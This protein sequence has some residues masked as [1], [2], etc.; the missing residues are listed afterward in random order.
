MDIDLK[1]E[2]KMRDELLS[3]YEKQIEIQEKF[4]QQQKELIEYLQEHISKIT[5]I[6][7]GF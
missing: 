5:D 6:V 3:G 1:K 4:I 2:I 7:S